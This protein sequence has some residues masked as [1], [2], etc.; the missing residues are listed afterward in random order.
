MPW[1][2]FS[3]RARESR[4]VRRSSPFAITLWF[5]CGNWCSEHRTDGFLAKEEL[6]E[7]WRPL[8]PFDHKAVAA[9]CCE[10]GLLIDHGTHYEVH[11]YLEFNPTKDKLDA[12]RASDTRRAAAYRSR[13]N[14]LKK[15]GI[16]TRDNGVRHAANDSAESTPSD[17]KQSDP[18][19]LTTTASTARHAPPSRPDPVPSRSEEERES[20]LDNPE[21]EDSVAWVRLGKLY[22]SIFDSEQAGSRNP[23]LYDDQRIGSADARF[24][25]RLSKLVTAESARCGLGERQVF[26]AAARAFL[27]DDG[28]RKKGFKLAFF[29]DDFTLY[30]DRSDIEAAS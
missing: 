22:K 2:K 8:Y 18:P 28:Q 4:K 5:A 30:V 3:D 15:L 13:Q 19:L 14:T 25:I 12:K 7:A 26:D 23:R 6:F 9:E 17:E 1:Q 10:R 29:A 16:V 27:R 20:A 11:D 21:L 24:F